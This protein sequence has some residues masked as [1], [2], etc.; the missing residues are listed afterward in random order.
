MKP[1]SFQSPDPASPILQSSKHAKDSVDATVAISAQHFAL[2]IATLEERLEVKRLV[3]LYCDGNCEDPKN[4][5][6]HGALFIDKVP[7]GLGFVSKY[8]ASLIDKTTSLAIQISDI[9][10][11][12][13]IFEDLWDSKIK[14]TEQVDWRIYATT[15]PK[16]AALK[17]GPYKYFGAALQS[18]EGLYSERSRVVY[19]RRVP[20]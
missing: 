8:D 13:V 11:G 4:W 3:C 15:P 1:I 12:E 2:G 14:Y 16:I 9:A 18:D 6:E 19:A 7:L 10:T 17:P 20:Q 5:Y